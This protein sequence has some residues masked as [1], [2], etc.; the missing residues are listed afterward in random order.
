MKDQLDTLAELLAKALQAQ[1]DAQDDDSFN[2]PSS[3]HREQGRIWLEGWFDLNAA[4]DNLPAIR[5][6][7]D[8]VERLKQALEPF[9]ELADNFVADDEDDNDLYRPP[10]Y[11][12]QMHVR[13]G[14]LRSAQKATGAA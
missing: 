8:D 9:A 12:H 6:Q 5:E 1:M 7:A 2:L 11:E 10:L 3:I 14:W 13:V 4:I